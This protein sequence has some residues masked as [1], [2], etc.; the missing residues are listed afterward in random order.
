M[1]APKRVALAFGCLL[2]ALLF[3][4][5][6]SAVP[7]AVHYGLRHAIPV[8]Q[9]MPVYRLFALPGLVLAL[10]FVLLIKDAEG[11]RAL[12]ILAIG[13]CIGPGFM[14]TWSLLA[15]HGRFSWQ[16][17]G[18][19]LLMPLEIGFLTTILY[20]LLLRRFGKQRLPSA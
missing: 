14:G 9:I 7:M 18:A 4:A 13:T 12:I 15:S 17:D 5:V 2:L 16:G 8:V 1:T 6:S 10:P 3:F 11:P 20:V 19:F